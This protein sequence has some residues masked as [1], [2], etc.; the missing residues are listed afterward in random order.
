MQEYIVK[1]VKELLEAKA[2]K[3]HKDIIFRFDYQEHRS[4]D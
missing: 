4:S 3:K 2:N 1:T